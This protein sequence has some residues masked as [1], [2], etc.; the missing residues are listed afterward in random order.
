VVS[1]RSGVVNAASHQAGATPGAW[2]SIYGFR[3]AQSTRAWTA[4][5]IVAGRLPEKLDGVSVTMNNKPAA[6]YFETGFP[7]RIRE[8]RIRSS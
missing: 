5:D 4:A 6:V 3:L 7:D 1:T 8:I 2:V